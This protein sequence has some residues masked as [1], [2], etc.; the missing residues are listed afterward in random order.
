MEAG[1][2]LV[3]HHVGLVGLE[4]LGGDARGLVDQVGG[5][6]EHG[7]AALL[8]RARAHGAVALR[9]EVGVAPDDVDLVHRDAGL[10]VGEHAPRGD[11]ALAVRR[12][13]GVDDGAAVVEHL[14]ASVL[15]GA[16]AAGDLDVRADA[17]AQLLHVARRA[18]AGL[19]G[20]Q[21]GVAGG[22]ERLVERGLVVA[23]VVGLADGG[24]VRL[25]ELA[26]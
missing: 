17:D 7:V 24:G 4:Q 1:R 12:G 3:E 11:V 14:D 9:H 13:A 15:A 20:A 19:L 26:G 25:E 5:R 8:Q 6:E 22:G 21:V 10:L 16:D 2:V 23:H 18:A